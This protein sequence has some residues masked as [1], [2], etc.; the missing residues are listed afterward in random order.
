MSFDA[1]WASARADGEAVGTRLNGAPGAAGGQADLAV[2]QDKLGRIGSAAFAL[3]G[4]LAADGGHARGVT[5]EASAAMTVNG[6]R[7]GA[8]LGTV[9]DTWDSQ[10]NTLLDAVANISNHLD[11]SAASHAREEKDIKTAFS[12]SRIDEYLK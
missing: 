2:D 12:V 4:R 10:L 9:H 1:E 7:T 6:F 11:Y 8:A 5:A 3:H